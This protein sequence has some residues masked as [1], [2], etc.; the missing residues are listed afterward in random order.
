MNEH[1]CFSADEE[2][3]ARHAIQASLDEDHAREDL[4]TALAVPAG[5]RGVFLVR[6]RSWGVLAGVEAIAWTLAA[7]D[8]DVQVETAVVDGSL[9]AEPTEIARIEGDRRAVLSAERSFLNFIG[10]LSGVATQ[11]RRFVDA[12]GAGC[13][14]LDTRKTLPGWR[15]LHK[16]AVR[17]GG[18]HNHRMHLADGILL[19]DNHRHPELDLEGL[20]AR[21]REQHP[22]VPIVIEVD[23]F[24]QFDRAILLEPDRLLLDNFDAE[25]VREAVRRRNA[26]SS[27]VELEVSGGVDL[28]SAPGLAAA[29]ADCLSVGAITH[30]APVWDVGLDEVEEAR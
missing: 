15:L 17:C 10:S 8:A 4:T 2:Q 28:H 25:R 7:L 6:N 3:R 20:F 11:T 21:A 18:G 30:S 5:T 16:Y 27:R 1:W 26:L 24:Q 19:K 23:D 29:G 13:R 12:V 22:E 9:C 14:I